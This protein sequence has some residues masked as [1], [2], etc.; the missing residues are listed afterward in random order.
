LTW[1]AGRQQGWSTATGSFVV[2]G[3]CPGQTL[4]VAIPQTG[5]RPFS[6]WLDGVSIRSAG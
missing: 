2:P 4:M 5:G 1:G 3:D 6:L